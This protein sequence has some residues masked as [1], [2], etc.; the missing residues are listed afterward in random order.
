[1][2]LTRRRKEGRRRQARPAHRQQPQQQQQ[3]RSSTRLLR[4]HAAAQL[5]PLIIPARLAH[6][7]PA[8]LADRLGPRLGGTMMG[9]STHM[10]ACLMQGVTAAGTRRMQASDRAQS[11]GN[12]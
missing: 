3:Q 6:L 8:V 12:T 1:M 7:A 10:T 5:L 4:L 2:Y 11:P 9:L